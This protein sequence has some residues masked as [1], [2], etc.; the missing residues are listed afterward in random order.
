L[1]SL[2]QE[3]GFEIVS[4]GLGDYGYERVTAEAVTK[5][6]MGERSYR[7]LRRSLLTVRPIREVRVVACRTSQ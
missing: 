1:P 2:V 3:A 6:R 7:A 4:A 5:L